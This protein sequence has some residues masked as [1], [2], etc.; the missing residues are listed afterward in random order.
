MNRLPRP[1]AA[2]LVAYL[3]A[4]AWAQPPGP[5]PARVAVDAARLERVESR[6]EV[7]GEIRAVR[8]AALAAAEEGLVLSVSVEIG[9]WVREAQVLARLD[10][11][12]RALDLDRRHAERRAAEATIAE[13]ESMI[14]KARRD[15]D[16]LKDL[17][18][19]AGASQN[20]VDDAM[21][22]LSADEA[23]LARAVAD[24]ES[25]RVDERTAE[26]RLADMVIEAP[27]A[28]SVTRKII[29]AGEWVSAGDA[30]IELVSIDSVDAMLDVPERF[31]APLSSDNARVELRV[32][33]LNRV[34]EAPVTSVMAMGDRL[35]RT[36]AVRV[37]I[38]NTESGP[39]RGALRPGMSVV[40]LVPTGEPVEALTVHKDGVLRNDAGSYVYFEAGG[41]A[42]VAPV[43]MLYAVGERVVV[44]S[45]LL[46]PG[47]RVVTEG[48]E[49]VFPGQP[50]A[51]IG[52]PPA[53]TEGKGP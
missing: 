7:T 40:G 25:A 16:R 41:A 14:A 32:P 26:K 47:M 52:D 22:Q 18:K 48:N 8:Q 10:D 20:E 1:F 2:L 46:K 35:A 12:L 49:R 9:E 33:A 50:L 39:A 51:V 4:A 28:G 34:I 53:D 44:R 29:E 17:Q 11:R 45:T 31:I 38:D 37:R 43:E 24:A 30:V 3:A 6:R 42:T 13:H 23:R 36:F 15:L 21:T 19:S 27:F 5:P